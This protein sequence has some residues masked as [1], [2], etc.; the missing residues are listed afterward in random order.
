RLEI[1]TRTEYVDGEDEGNALKRLFE[2]GHW[3]SEVTQARKD[4]SRFPV[5]SSVALVRG[6]DGHVIALVA[7]NRDISERKQA[8]Q[9]LQTANDLLEERV[10]ERTG[11]LH[12]V[13]LALE[14][15]SKLKDEFLAGMSH[16]LRTPLNAV[17]SLSE[18][19]REGVY[20][21]LTP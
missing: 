7:V 16:E 12:E 4:G 15:A 17:I 10:R 8:E 6:E 9:A 5:I 13:N 18:S 19:M 1:F 2:D 3:Q 11:E 20:G 14:S 21:R